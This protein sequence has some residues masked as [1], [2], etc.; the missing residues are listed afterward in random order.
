[1][2]RR[3]KLVAA[4]LVLVVGVSLAGYVSNTSAQVR[5]LDINRPPSAKFEVKPFATDKGAW[6][7][8]KLDR[9]GGQVWWLDR[10]KWIPIPDIDPLPSDSYEVEVVLTDNGWS[11]IR[12]NTQT[13][14]SWTSDKTRWIATN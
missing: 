5:V 12:Y 2:N 13:G 11:C 10:Q 4:A 1:M 6:S 14:Q 7:A 3:T 9:T 8:V